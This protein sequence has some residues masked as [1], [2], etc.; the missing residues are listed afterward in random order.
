M[1]AV[2]RKPV[3]IDW[4][5]LEMAL[6]WHDPEGSRHFLHLET[7]E[8]VLW[9]RDGDTP[10]SDA[11][12]EGL[13]DG[14]LV[15]IDPLPSSIEYGWMEE[16]VATVRNAGL[17]RQLEAALGGNR[18]FRRFKDVLA[19]HPAERERWFAFHGERLRAAA[20]EWLEENGIEAPTRTSGT[21]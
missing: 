11:I 19:D 8:V 1:T 5:D 6:T 13:A 4:D 14:R 15:A 20:R 3:A 10:S 18:P 9:T 17:R 2:Q 21:S 7:G 16:F 12:D